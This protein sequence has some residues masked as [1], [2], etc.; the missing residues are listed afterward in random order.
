MFGM[1]HQPGLGGIHDP[2]L[3][4]RRHR[5]GRLVQAGAGL[6]LDKGDQAALPGDDVDLAMG[7]AKAACEDAIALGQQQSCGTAFG[8]EAGIERSDAFRRSR[9][10]LRASA[11]RLCQSSP[12]PCDLLGQFQR[13][14]INGTTRATGQF[15]RMRYG[16]LDAVALQ[17]RAQ[18]GIEIV[19]SHRLRIRRRWSDHQ[20][21]FAA[22]LQPIG[23][24]GQV[25]NRAAIDL[26]MHLGEFAA[27][28]RIAVAHDVGE[29]GE[30]VLHTVA[31][32]E[33]H[34]RRVDGSQLRQP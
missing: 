9:L 20:N 17:G 6:H 18:Q 3:L 24:L 34:Q 32:F 2:G 26:F 1:R 23:L 11:R 16:I 5:I 27:D 25:G 29:I 10:W 15:D 33:H 12:L 14:S 31:G 8:R 13:A 30:R 28:R 19:F 21:K 4:A 22:G 7:R